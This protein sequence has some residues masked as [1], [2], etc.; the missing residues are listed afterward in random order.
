MVLSTFTFRVVCF[1]CILFFICIFEK[2]KFPITNYIYKNIFKDKSSLIGDKILV[3]LGCLILLGFIWFVSVIISSIPAN[4]IVVNNVKWGEVDYRIDKAI[5]NYKGHEVSLFDDYIDNR[6]NCW[7]ILKPVIYGYSTPSYNLDPQ[8]I[9][10]DT[11][12]LLEHGPS[13][14]FEGVPERIMVN[15]NSGTQVLWSLEIY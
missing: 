15:K 7:F 2:F 12:V 10:G 8:K 9:E 1:F 14:K 11:I 3:S 5:G 13:Y 4:V 6:T